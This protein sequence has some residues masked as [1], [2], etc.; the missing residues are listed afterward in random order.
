MPSQEGF[1]RTRRG[2][3]VTEMR[4]VR[5]TEANLRNNHLYVSELRDILPADIFGPPKRQRSGMAGIEIILDGL[6]ETIIT[7]IPR[8]AKTGKPRGFL[9][10]RGSIGRFYRHHHV[11]ADSEVVFQRLGERKY[12]LAYKS[13]GSSS[14]KP[15]AVSGSQAPAWEPTNPRLL[16]RQKPRAAEFFA[17]IGLVRLA[18]ERQGW[19]VVFANDID[20]DKAKMYCDNWP[21]IIGDR[22]NHLVVG[23]IHDLNP[24]DIPDCEL[25]TASFPCNDLSI[26]GRWEGLSG[27]ESS[28]FWGLIEL[29]DS[30][31]SRKPPLILL[32]NV[33]GFLL[34][35]KGSDFEQALLALNERGYN[36]DAF[37]LNAVRWTTS[38][39]VHSLAA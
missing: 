23:D 33:V 38:H 27:K 35:N 20:E 6:N 25:W 9:R 19:E 30:V 36:V 34:R 13:N 22:A 11:T 10:D 2:G 21:G 29:L 16:P 31:K 8:E 7:D 15:R 18:L 32:E 12:R 26:A 24:G 14:G 17:G 39:D 4:L 1:L 37:I 5:V 3:T 28:A